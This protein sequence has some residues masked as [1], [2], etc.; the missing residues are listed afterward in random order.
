[1]NRR[2]LLL[3]CLAGFLIQGG[4]VALMVLDRALILARG[5][6]IRLAAL[7][8]DPR[9]LLRGDYVVLTYP[10]SQVDGAGAPA[11]SR[12][13]V[14]HVGLRQEGAGWATLPPSAERPPEGLAL[15]GRITAVEERPGGG[16][17]YRVAYDI[18]KFFVPEGRGRE[19]E[20][21]RNARRVEVDVAVASDGRAALRRLLTDGVVRYEDDLF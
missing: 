3:G 17:R 4:A 8:V 7:P 18:E 2:R 11:L 16:R 10:I 5:T 14:V 21:M 19:I 13:D 12:G 1:M 6:E 15:K 20:G 9:D